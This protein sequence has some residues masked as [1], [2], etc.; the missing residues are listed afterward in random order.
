[1]KKKEKSKQNSDLPF[2]LFVIP[3]LFMVAIVGYICLS[4]IAKNNEM[5]CNYIGDIWIYELQTENSNP[6][7]GCYTWEEVYK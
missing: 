6:R 3:A 4:K 5:V 7:V 1:M 2:F